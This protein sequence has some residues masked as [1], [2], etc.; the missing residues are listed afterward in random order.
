MKPFLRVVATCIA[1]LATFYFVFFLALFV[2]LA[3]AVAFIRFLA[4]LI[5]ALLAGRYVWKRTDGRAS[6]HGL[7]ESVAAGALI[8][9]VIGF[10]IGF[11]GPIIVTPSAN[12]GPL[13]GIFITGPLGVVL[14]AIG[15][16]LYWA[17]RGRVVAAS[18]DGAR[19]V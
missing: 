19:T 3:G 11:V 10:L 9:G 17:M 6:S 13:L 12:Q 2:P 4:A 18:R 15:G 14:G 1:G 16:G 5:C 8:V 7:L